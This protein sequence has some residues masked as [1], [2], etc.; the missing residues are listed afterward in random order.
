MSSPVFR[1]WNRKRKIS[2]SACLSAKQSRMRNALL[3]AGRGLLIL[4]PTSTAVLLTLL[5]HQVDLV[6]VPF[7]LVWALVSLGVAL[8]APALW[9][10]LAPPARGIHGSMLYAKWAVALGLLNLASALCALFVLGSS[11]P[12][13]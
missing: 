12:S 7:W 1:N 4:V 11:S 3:V 6:P 8:E 13:G 9:D 2:K 5:P 10:A